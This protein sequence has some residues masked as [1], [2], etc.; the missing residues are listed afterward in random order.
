MVDLGIEYTSDG[1]RSQG[2]MTPFQ[3]SRRQS[4]LDH[5]GDVSSH[6]NSKLLEGSF[7]PELQDANN[8]KTPERRH[9]SDV[10]TA[11]G[12]KRAADLDC[13]PFISS[14]TSLYIDDHQSV[15]DQKAQNRSQ[16]AS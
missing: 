8:S 11:S 9:S 14:N 16:N 6:L 13:K 10:L 12:I 3:R 7:N 4:R 2:T 1:S 15:F 5:S